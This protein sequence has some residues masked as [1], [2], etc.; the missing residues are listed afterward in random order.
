[1]SEGRTRDWLRLLGFE[2]VDARRYLFTPP[3]VRRVREGGGLLEKRGPML[4]P[5]LAG[6]YLIKARKRVRV[7]TPIRPLWNRPAAV[8]GGIIEP[9][10]RNAA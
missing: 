3:W 8:V 5:P 9:T 6:A 7:L 4:V 2:I 10:S 1:M